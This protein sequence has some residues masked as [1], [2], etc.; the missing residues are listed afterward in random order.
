[1]FHPSL[2]SLLKAVETARQK[3]KRIVFT[4]GCFDILHLGHV[5]YLAEAKACG[6]LLV[7]GLNT[8]RSVRELKGPSRPLQSETDRAQI[9][10]ALKSVDHT[11]LFD[12]DTPLKLIEALQP[13][14]L[15]KGGDWP[16]DKIV[17]ADVVLKRGGQVKSLQFLEGRSTTKVVNRMAEPEIK[18]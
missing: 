6:D 3:G 8:D 15:V 2:P 12:E 14:V 17:G 7:V 4:N 18:K 5:Q 10:V 11:I 16:I 1:M 13:D 9:L